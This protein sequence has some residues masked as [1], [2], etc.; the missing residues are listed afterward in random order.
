MKYFVADTYKDMERVGEPFESN[1][2]MYTEVVGT[3]DRCGGSGIF[4][5][6]VENGHVVPHPAYG[7]VCLKCGGEGRVAKVVR[8]Y[9]EKE[10]NSAQKAKERRRVKAAEATEARAK[11]R[12]AKAF[13]TWLERNGFDT[14]G[15][16]FLIYGNTY[17]I[18]D[19]LKAQ[20][21]KFSKELK[22]HGPA[23]V[24]VPEDCFVDRVHWSSIFIWGEDTCNMTFT[25]EGYKF[26]EDLFTS[27]CL[28]E[29][30]GEVGERLRNLTVVFE[31]ASSFDGYYGETNIYR[32][33]CNGAQLSWFTQTEKDLREG[34][35]YILTG[36]VKEHKVYGN[37][38]TTYLSR[39]IVKGV[40]N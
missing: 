8:L 23:A 34:A 17:P 39:C 40:S 2:K 24:E 16:T 19:E 35:E 27:H 10:Y 14:E 22:W 12:K 4:A 1:G 20:G 31:G 5:S 25:E 21:Y 32:F 30:L 3:C 28:G 6:H 9:T 18:K 13:T 15:N 37:V 38:K 11:A 7:G 29:Y 36:T 33:N 26:L